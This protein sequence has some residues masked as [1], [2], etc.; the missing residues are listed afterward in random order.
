MAGSLGGKK[1]YIRAQLKRAMAHLHTFVE[2]F[3]QSDP[4]L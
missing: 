1:A 2:A 3:G 4:K